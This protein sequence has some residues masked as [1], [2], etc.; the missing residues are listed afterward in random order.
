MSL[1]TILVLTF[2]TLA[3]SELESSTSY[4]QGM[5]AK[6]LSETAVNMVIGQLRKATTDEN[7]QKPG[8]RLGV[9][10]GGGEGV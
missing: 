10:A 4:S 9:P 7:N 6:H 8:L 3:Q 1:A 5:E 2:F